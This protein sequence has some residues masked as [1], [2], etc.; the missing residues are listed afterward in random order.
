MFCSFLALVLKKALGG[1]HRCCLPPLWLPGRRSSPIWITADR[2]RNRG[3]TAK[4]HNRRPFRARSP[5]AG[6]SPCG[7]PPASRCRRPC[8]S[9]P[10]R[11]ILTENVSADRCRGAP[12]AI[13]DQSPVK[14]EPKLKMGHNTH[15]P[16]FRGSYKPSCPAGETFAGRSC[17]GCEHIIRRQRPPDPLRLELARPA[18]PSRRSRPWSALGTDKDLPLLGIRSGLL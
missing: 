13:A 12:I 8:A 3:R 9:P 5:A 15:R 10:P 2:D 18:R 14:I 16:D 1:P 17:Y 7:C 11:L 6:V 4:R